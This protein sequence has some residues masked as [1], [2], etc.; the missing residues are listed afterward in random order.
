MPVSDQGINLDRYMFVPRSLIILMHE[1]KVLLLKGANDKR[2]WAGLY[3]GV[4]GHIESGEDVLS[5]A[6]RELFEETGLSVPGLWL[7]GI[8][9]VDTKTNPGVG[10]FIFT[11]D[12]TDDTFA[13]SEEGEFEWI[14]ISELDRLP[15]VEDLSK[16][17]PKILEMKPGDSPFFGHS[18]YN[19]SGN[20]EI[21]FR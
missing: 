5:A 21:S 13:L 19:E 14:K 9:T 12:S 16:I 17:I 10:L 11:G 3:N 8:V 15:L 4:G 20:L 7:C 1:D 6:Q 18:S 2:L